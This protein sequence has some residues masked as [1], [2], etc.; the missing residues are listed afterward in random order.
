MIHIVNSN[1]EKNIRSNRLSLQSE[2]NKVDVLKQMENVMRK[3]LF[4]MFKYLKP[5]ANPI[6]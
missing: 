2:F 6:R 3:S 1:L 5:R 4:S